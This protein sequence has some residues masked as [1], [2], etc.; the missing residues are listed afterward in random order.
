MEES[1]VLT[2]KLPRAK[3]WPECGGW[4]QAGDKAALG[5]THSLT[6]HCWARISFAHTVPAAVGAAQ[7]QPGAKLPLPLMW[8]GWH[9]PERC[10]AMSPCLSGAHEYLQ[11]ELAGPWD[12]LR[13]APVLGLS[14]RVRGSGK[15]DGLLSSC[16]QQGCS[17]VIRTVPQ[18][19]STAGSLF[20]SPHFPPSSP[21]SAG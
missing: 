2:K 9:F 15:W 12:G 16:P 13:E 10:Q 1:R 8:L 19:S 14:C 3:T 6:A 20:L 21:L 17:L 18:L 4:S 7:R 11:A 5:G